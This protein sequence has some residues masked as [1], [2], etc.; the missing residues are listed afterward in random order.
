M[1]IT[2]SS[3]KYSFVRFNMEQNTS[4][5]PNETDY[6][7]PVVNQADAKFQFQII[8]TTQ[9]EADDIMALAD[10]DVQLW[11][12]EGA[13]NIPASAST[14][15]LR[16]LSTDDSLYFKKFRTGVKE[17]TFVWD[18]PLLNVVSIVGLNNCFQLGVNILTEIVADF[19]HVSNCFKVVPASCYLTL[20][21][22]RCDEDQYGFRY[23]ETDDFANRI[24]MPFYS[25]KKQVLDDDV[26]YIKSGGIPKLVST[27]TREEHE[28]I[29]D[30]MPADMHYKLKFA[31][32]S[33]YVYVTGDK[34]TGILTKSEGYKIGWDSETDCDA[35]AA[36][37]AYSSPFDARNTNCED[38]EELVIPDPVP[39]DADV[40]AS[41]DTEVSG[42]DIIVTVLWTNA[43]GT[44]PG[45]YTVTPFTQLAPGNNAYG[46]PV[47]VTVD[48]YS[49]T[50]PSTTV[51]TFGFKIT[52]DCGDGDTR[53]TFITYILPI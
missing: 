18:Q 28:I 25:A 24:R 31:L 43:G 37:K 38:C 17:V 20:I 40:V 46:A 10:G 3:P 16:D 2:L 9:E 1:S 13:D 52:A 22:Y 44:P 32:S 19:V 49:I 8:S 36:T 53:S 11:I 47:D 35:P 50:V 7:V 6:C 21:E 5:C 12:L 51:G 26:T 45:G 23:C 41:I 39:C 30:F 27:T 34:Y 15:I 4:C 29:T 48:E 33:D 14:N 42:D